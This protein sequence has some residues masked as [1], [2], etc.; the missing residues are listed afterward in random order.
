MMAGASAASSPAQP[1]GGIDDHVI[2]LPLFLGR[3]TARQFRRM[4]GGVLA[5]SMP[6]ALGLWAFDYLQEK[7]STPR[8]LASINLGHDVRVM[9]KAASQVLQGNT[10]QMDAVSQRAAALDPSL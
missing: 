8:I 4:F 3:R 5:I 9:A 7:N 10:A 6:L 2:A 1:A